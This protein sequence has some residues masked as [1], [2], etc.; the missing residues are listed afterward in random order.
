MRR[1]LARSEGAGDGDDA[2]AGT[3]G[4]IRAILTLLLSA[5]AVLAILGTDVS[6]RPSS[7]WG[8][9]DIDR[10]DALS[11]TGGHQGVRLRPDGAGC[12]VVDQAASRRPLPPSAEAVDASVHFPS[13]IHDTFARPYFTGFDR[14]GGPAI[15]ASLMATVGSFGT[16]LLHALSLVVASSCV[17]LVVRGLGCT[18]AAA[19]VAAALVSLN[20]I[21]M[22][23]GHIMMSEK[24]LG[25]HSS[26]DASLS[27]ALVSVLLALTLPKGPDRRFLLAGLVLGA[28][29]GVM[30]TLA[31]MAVPVAFAALA[32]RRPRAPVL[33]VCGALVT[34]LPWMFLYQYLCGSPVVNSTIGCLLFCNPEAYRY[35]TFCDHAIASDSDRLVVHTLPLAGRKVVFDGLLNWPFHDRIVRMPGYPFP[36]SLIIPLVAVSSF[37]V[38]L[39]AAGLVG[40]WTLLR[41]SWR[42]ALA[43]ALWILPLAAILLVQENWDFGK[44]RFLAPLVAAPAVLVGIG[45]DAVM[46]RPRAGAIELLGAVAL[47]LIALRMCASYHVAPDERW[48]ERFPPDTMLGIGGRAGE[49]EI[50]SRR[51][52]FLH[53]DLLP[54][55]F[56]IPRTSLSRLSPAHVEGVVGNVAYVD[57]TGSPEMA[58]AL[59]LVQRHVPPYGLVI[60]EDVNAQFVVKAAAR[61]CAAAPDSAVAA[62]M[63]CTRGPVYLLRVGPGREAPGTSLVHDTPLRS[64]DVTLWRV[65]H[66]GECAVT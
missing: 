38:L 43:F 39:T 56:S 20:T 18:P 29:V 60:T 25:T 46:R 61:R 36:M 5:V 4:P 65:S 42:I 50:Q 26:L 19:L 31:V 44:D 54:E 2:A 49:V 52:M 53:P 17:F 57:P 62:R 22:P 3:S 15:A 32:R 55:G 6:F 34:M 37:G 66:A 24:V 10:M 12:D 64:G 48:Y 27:L 40:A 16:P 1:R 8:E 11:V 33:L 23:V 30:N 45:L 63:L 58:D 9:T 21:V 51:E 41:H 14:T 28:L 59:A 35:P 47:V 7:L 13:F